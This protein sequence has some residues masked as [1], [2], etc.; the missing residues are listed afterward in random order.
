MWE[1]SYSRIGSPPRYLRSKSK[2]I[3]RYGRAMTYTH[4]LIVLVCA[5]R[6]LQVYN[7]S[8]SSRALGWDT[9]NYQ[10]NTHRYRYHVVNPQANYTKLVRQVFQNDYHIRVPRE[11]YKFTN[12][13]VSEECCQFHPLAVIGDTEETAVYKLD[14]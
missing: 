14:P 2:L 11:K 6:L 7:T 8:Q 9:N 1:G 3:V 10:A 4:T 5:P 13:L 12:C